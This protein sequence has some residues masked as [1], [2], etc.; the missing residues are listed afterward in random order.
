MEKVTLKFLA[1]LVCFFTLSV[2]AQSIKKGDIVINPYIGFPRFRELY[3]VSNSYSTNNN[4][5]YFSFVGEEKKGTLLGLRTEYLFTDKFGIGFDFIY[6]SFRLVGTT[7]HFNPNGIDE[8]YYTEAFM[9]RIRF[10]LKCNYHFIHDE[11]VDTYC[12][13]GIGT[14]HTIYSGIKNI[15][16]FDIYKTNRMD[17]LFSFR[18]A[19]GTTYYFTDDIGFNAEV[20][21][22]GPL[23][24]IGAAIKL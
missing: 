1:T 16:N 4:G 10:Q 5:D 22:G 9:S 7:K 8:M 11:S 15:P 12:G 18:A 6:K 17:F 24:S 20:G 3:Y 13:I 14:N 2:K 19:G 23:L 21:L